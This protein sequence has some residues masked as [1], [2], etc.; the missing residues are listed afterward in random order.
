[1][2]FHA[3]QRELISCTRILIL[4]IGIWICLQF[5]EVTQP[6]SIERTST[7]LICPSSPKFEAHLSEAGES[8]ICLFYGAARIASNSASKLQAIPNPGFWGSTYNEI[9]YF[10]LL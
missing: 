1:M 7:E 2:N 9:A 4:P 10:H 8:C 3:F 6:A 5:S